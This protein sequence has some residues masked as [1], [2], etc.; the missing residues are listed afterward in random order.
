MNADALPRLL[1]RIPY[2]KGVEETVLGSLAA[3]GKFIKFADGS[4]IFKK[5]EKS[6]SLYV[7]ILGRVKI[8]GSGGQNGDGE[9][10]LEKFSAFGELSFFDGCAREADA[11]AGSEV[12]LFSIE[13]EA[14]RK[15]L[16]TYPDAAL[17]IIEN[18]TLA[19][20]QEKALTGRLMRA[21]AGEPA[22]IP[23]F[24]EAPEGNTAGGIE[25]MLYRKEFTCPFCAQKF[26]TFK[27]RSRFVKVVKVDDD[28]CNHYESIN[29]LFYEIAVCPG[30]GYSFHEEDGLA[31]DEKAREEIEKRLPAVWRTRDFGGVRD[32]G[33]AVE[34][35]KL[36]LICQVAR[37]VKDSQKAMLYL[38]LAWLYRF[39]HDRENEQLC[40][41]E[42]VRYFTSSFERESFAD[43]KSEI[44]IL[45]LIGVLNK[46]L[47]NFKEASRWLDRVLRHPMKGSYSGVVNRAR[48]IW[49]DL[50]KEMKETHQ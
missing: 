47:G 29:P 39:A 25:D 45:Y 11:A 16:K 22:E 7:I 26:A 48:N 46:K 34:S 4:P 41:S 44:N 15:L 9:T 6:S 18:L 36:A 19:L 43:P 32:I 38:K 49:Q 31:V 17:K 8:S 14:F 33:L 21:G 23:V 2:F 3:Q 10:L 35:F 5:G 28:L 42:A 20:R 24:E 13:R 12:V 1:S 37:R 27:A 50:R 40:I 30:C